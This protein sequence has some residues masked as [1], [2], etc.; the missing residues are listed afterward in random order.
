MNRHSRSGNWCDCIAETLRTGLVRF[1]AAL[2]E[3]IYA[4]V[5]SH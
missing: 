1:T 4:K 3:I 5:A 2:W